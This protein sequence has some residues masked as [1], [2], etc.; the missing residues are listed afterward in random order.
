MLQI[1]P[2]FLQITFIWFI[3]ESP[4]W[5]VSQDRDEEAF[6]ILA[7]YHADGDREDSFV[8]AEFAQIRE[9]ITLEN[10]ASK[11]RWLELVQTRANLHR[12]LIAVCVGLFS[13]WSGNG[14]VSYYLAQ[15][16]KSIGITDSRKQNQINLGLQCWN[17]VSG[18]SGAFITK[19][20]GRR[21]Q[22]LI[23]FSGMTI[24]FAC[25]TGAS[26]TFART[27]NHNA[28][29]A[30]VG[31]IF[32]YYGFYNLMHPLAWIYIPEIFPYYIRSKGSSITQF[33]NRASAAFNTFVNPIELANL[34]WKF[35]IV[36][37]VWLAIET[38]TI[39]FVY[40]ETKGP[41]LE[42]LAVLFE[43][44]EARVGQL[45]VDKAGDTSEHIE[46]IDY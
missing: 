11:R 8:L 39:F 36:Y 16:L 20:L 18:V 14:L 10:E 5:L 43:G 33:L 1:V 3:P 30:V 28:A 32:I 17:L 23:A 35:Y 7:K 21:T 29:G 9:T 24:V 6:A 2:S 26:A 41:T 42:E 46:E 13:Q 15:V 37:V 38:T 45:I 12:V 44:K 27:A 4:R 31:M 25:W 34:G 22:F 40:K 19:L